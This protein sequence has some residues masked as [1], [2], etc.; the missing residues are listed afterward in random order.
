MSERRAW[1]SSEENPYFSLYGAERL[2]E[3]L[4]FPEKNV[5]TLDDCAEHR[6]KWQECVKT[7]EGPENALK[8]KLHNCNDYLSDYKFCMVTYKAVSRYKHNCY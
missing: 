3:G 8:T 1:K 6:D 4:Q 2:P 5:V 7:I